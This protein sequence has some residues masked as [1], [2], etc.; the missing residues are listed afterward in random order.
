MRIASDC[1]ILFDRSPHKMCSVSLGVSV[2]AKT[3]Q[4]PAIWMQAADSAGI[5]S[6]VVAEQCLAATTHT[7]RLS[8]LLS[9]SS[10]QPHRE[11]GRTGY[12]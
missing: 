7:H 2:M 6:Q 5:V 12:S 3:N 4:R 8:L 11:P 1:G 10:I 9:L